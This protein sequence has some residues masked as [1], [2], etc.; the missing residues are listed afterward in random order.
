MDVLIELKRN[1]NK[2]TV[3]NH[4]QDIIL[5]DCRAGFSEYPNHFF[6]IESGRT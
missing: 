6:Y 4:R 1:Y 3:E 5:P 2:V